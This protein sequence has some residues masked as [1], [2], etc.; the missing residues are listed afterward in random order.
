[1][2]QKFNK[3]VLCIPGPQ[4]P[5]RMDA[6]LSALGEEFKSLA[7]GACPCRCFG[8]AGTVVCRPSTP[9]ATHPLTPQSFSHV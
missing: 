3:L 8:I 6:Y 2:Q 7:D 1:M 9:S 4:Q 5:P